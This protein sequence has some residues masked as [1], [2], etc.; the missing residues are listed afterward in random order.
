MT[1]YTQAKLFDDAIR[2]GEHFDTVISSTPYLVYTHD[3]GF[4]RLYD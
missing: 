1:N 4:L 3:N 2:N